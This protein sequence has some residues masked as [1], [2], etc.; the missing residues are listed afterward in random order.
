MIVCR[1][2]SDLSGRPC[3]F[4]FYV[5]SIA[6][7]TAQKCHTDLQ[8]LENPENLSYNDQERSDENEP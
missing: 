1:E 8:L 7:E 2:E 5:H 3:C 4:C 6:G